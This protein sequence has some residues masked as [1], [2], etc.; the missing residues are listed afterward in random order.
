MDLLLW[1]IS[2]HG[3]TPS[4]VDSYTQNT[5]DGFSIY[6]YVVDEI[7][8]IDIYIAAVAHVEGSIHVEA[9]YVYKHARHMQSQQM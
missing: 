7:A 9:I 3:V 6:Y 5:T 2:H 1:R 4:H 8:I